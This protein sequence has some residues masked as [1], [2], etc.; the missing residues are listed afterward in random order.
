M[1]PWIL[2]APALLLFLLFVAVPLWMILVLSLLHGDRFG[3]AAAP[4]TL[5]NWR[6]VLGDKYYL[7]GLWRSL[8]IALWVTGLSAV[9]GIPEAFVLSRMRPVWRGLCL[10]IVLGPLLISIVV[11]TLGWAFLLGSTGLMNDAL[12]RLGL[13]PV[14][15]L[16][17]EAGVVVA[18]VHVF[19]PFMVLA[20][21]TS[22]QRLDPDLEW[23][24]A[25]LGA[26]RI[27]VLR[28]IVLP[29]IVPGVLA[30]GVTVFALAA[31]AFAT[32]AIIGGRR[33]K[34]AS[35]LAYDEFLNSLDWPLGAALAVT[36]L[37]GIAAIVGVVSRIAE[38]RGARGAL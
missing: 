37:V 10:V 14:A 21:W 26:R 6:E 23:A 4:L 16:Y 18:L 36:M 27:T 28:R 2:S 8:R 12:A 3:G 13:P 30:G 22:L 1:K 17:T 19:S 38:R 11:R 33:L 15:F 24:A 25:S 32:P 35:M 7:A 34:V 9:V 31:S 29:Q 20:V 5:A